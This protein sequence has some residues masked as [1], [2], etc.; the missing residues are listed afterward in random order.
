MG[1][2]MGC[3]VLC[4]AGLLSVCMG[5]QIGRRQRMDLM[6]AIHT[7]RV[8]QKDV[9]AYTRAMGVWLL[10]MGGGF[11]AAGVALLFCA[12]GWVLAAAAL[13]LGVAGIVHTQRKYNGSA[14]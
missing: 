7:R 10:W 5:W 12:A 3:T 11:A 1:Q 14:V 2:W 13:V 8:R 9:P 6:H 4:A